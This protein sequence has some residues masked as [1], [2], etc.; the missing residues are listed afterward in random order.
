MT[1]MQSGDCGECE[2]NTQQWTNTMN[3]PGMEMMLHGTGIMSHPPHAL[4]LTFIL[5][6]I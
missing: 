4:L 1:L 3:V 6:D 2:V 5:M